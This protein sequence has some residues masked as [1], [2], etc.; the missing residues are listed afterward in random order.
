MTEQK[1]AV[2]DIGSNSMRLTAYQRRGARLHLLFREKIMAGLAGYREEGC[3]SAAGIDRACGALEEFQRTLKVLRIGD[4]SVFA[5][6]SLRNIANTEETL[7]EIRRRTGC[8]VQVLSGEEEALYGWRGAMLECKTASGAFIDVGGA[9]TEIVLFE[10]G[11]PGQ[12]ASFPVGSLSL[13]RGCVKKLLPGRSAVRRMNRE[14]RSSI[15]ARDLLQFRK[16][17]PLVCTGGTARAVWKIARV[18]FGLSEEERRLS[19]PSFQRLCRILLKADRTAVDIMLKTVPDRVHTLLPGLLILSHGAE[20]L[21]AQELWISR[22]GV[23][24]G[25]LLRDEKTAARHP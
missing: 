6:A 24:E 2:I 4:V 18:L 3:L 19:M 15:D 1:Q 22:C 9:S 13:Y 25:F 17:S 7:R 16:C 20:L 21:D 12:M 5:T 14:I 23:R 8:R 11:E 10:Q